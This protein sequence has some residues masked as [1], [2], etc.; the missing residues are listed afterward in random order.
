MVLA[1]TSNLAMA[2]VFG[3]AIFCVTANALAVVAT[4][5]HAV[6]VRGPRRSFDAEDVSWS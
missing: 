1:L 5:A 3:L 4:I 6:R 2:R